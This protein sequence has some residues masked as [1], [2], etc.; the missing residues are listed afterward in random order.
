VHAPSVSGQL[1]SSEACKRCTNSLDPIARCTSAGS[2]VRSAETTRVAAVAVTTIFGG[3]GTAQN[4]SDLSRTE[5]KTGRVDVLC[6]PARDDADDVVAM[7]LSQLL[8]RQGHR[9]E[10]ISIG[11]TSEML[12]QVVDAN[13]DVVCISALPP[14]ALN[15]ARALYTKLR[16]RLP[17]LHIIICLWH[18]EGATQKAASRL[19]LA[20]G[21]GF[22]TTLPEVLQHIALRTATVA[23]GAQES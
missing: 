16:A 11:A 17:E 2:R 3:E 20:T 23:S 22:F 10:S 7:L 6:I 18:F 4:P 15:H 14:F 9:A 13:P 5:R 1:Q 12:S 21:H 19:K 8:E